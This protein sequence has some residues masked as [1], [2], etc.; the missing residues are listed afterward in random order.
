[1]LGGCL[2]LAMVGPAGA[3][4][5]SKKSA[6]NAT[7]EEVCVY[8]SRFFRVRTYEIHGL[9][10]QQCQAGGAWA[11]VGGQFC[12]VAQPKRVVGA[13]AKSKG[14]VCSKSGETYSIGAVFYD[15]ADD[16]SRCMERASPDD[17]DALDKEYFCEN[18]NP[19]DASENRW[20]GIEIEQGD[21]ISLRN[22]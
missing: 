1:M 16:C 22:W 7:V 8:G 13:H 19:G 21:A 11:D 4:Q 20:P 14:H 18:Q 5:P 6:P 10:C 17:W 12:E 9:S 2:L 3:Q 15:G